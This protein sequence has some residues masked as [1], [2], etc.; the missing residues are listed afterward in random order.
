MTAGQLRHP[1]LTYEFRLQVRPPQEGVDG[2]GWGQEA[3]T[4]Q[5]RGA[6]LSPWVEGCDPDGLLAEVGLAC[7]PDLA[8]DLIDQEQG[9]GVCV[10]NTFPWS[11]PLGRQ[12]CPPEA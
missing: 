1:G 8:G 9:L 11:F 7:L 6:V 4:G 2:A 12:I 10:F 3:W 5:G